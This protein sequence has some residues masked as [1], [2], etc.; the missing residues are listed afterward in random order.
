VGDVP[1]IDG[2]MSIPTQMWPSSVRISPESP[3]PQPT[4]R[5]NEGTSGL[6]S[7]EISE[8]NT[9][10]RG[11]LSLVESKMVSPDILRCYHFRLNLLDSRAASQ[12]QFEKVS[13]FEVYFWASVFP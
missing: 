3:E 8:F 2:A 9:E 5:M 12:A 6:P 7:E 1:S 13:Y 10:A 11:D 4:S